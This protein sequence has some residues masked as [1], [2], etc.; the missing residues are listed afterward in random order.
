MPNVT[1]RPVHFEDF[2]GHAFERL[3]FAY[4]LWA[5]WRDL[6]WYG[7]TG[8][9]MGRD[10]IG[11][12]PIDRTTGRRTVI[13]CANRDDLPLA[14]AKGDMKGAAAAPTGIPQAFKFVCRGAVSANRRD[15]I[16]KA[17]KAIKIGH[18]TIW[19]GAEFEEHLRLRAEFLLRR[20]VDGVPF[21]DDGAGLQAF[22]STFADIGD[23][24][25]LAQ[26][27]MP[28]ERPAF[29]TPFHA[30]SD[31]GAFRQAIEDTIGALSTG[32]WKSRDSELIR[33]IPSLRDIRDTGTRKA[34]EGIVRKLDDLRQL[35][36]R[37]MQDGSI[38]HCQC[39]DPN[40]PTFILHG[41]VGAELDQARTI[42]L[43]RV[44]AV[45]PNFDIRVG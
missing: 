22:V 44:R 11:I 16:A 3:V 9:D 36:K 32:L 6:A 38:E 4:H 35:F 12:E 17:A 41:D 19:S 15:A 31:L 5:D 8:S 27:A 26:M 37:R 1:V 34:L 7:Q 39:G 45:I 42:I 18:V 21:P 40:C 33:R 14:K 13:Q 10:I 25:A 29:W 2:D 43:E 20:F 28:F 24:E 23:A 30:E